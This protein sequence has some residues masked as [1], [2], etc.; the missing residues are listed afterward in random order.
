MESALRHTY[1]NMFADDIANGLE[2]DRVKFWQKRNFFL[3]FKKV[4]KKH[5]AKKIFLIHFKA[6]KFYQKYL[7]KLI[8]L[9]FGQFYIFF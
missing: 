6:I 3:S 9:K 2:R 7:K 5:F 8:C 4:T 1:N